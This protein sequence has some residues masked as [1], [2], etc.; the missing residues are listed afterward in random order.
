VLFVEF[1]PS[2]NEVWYYH[3]VDELQGQTNLIIKPNGIFRIY[4]FSMDRYKNALKMGYQWF[5]EEIEEI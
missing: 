1:D 2:V 4:D 5:D 3:L